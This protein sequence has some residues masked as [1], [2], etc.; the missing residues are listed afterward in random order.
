MMPIGPLMIEHRLI[1]RAIKQMRS[2]MERAKARKGFDVRF[3]DSWVDFI[4]TYADQVHHGKEE[5]I[6]FHDLESRPLSPELKRMMAGLIEDHVKA[7]KMVSELVMARDQYAEGDPTAFGRLMALGAEMVDFYPAHIRKEDQ[8]FFI[9]VMEYFTKGEKD[10]M[11]K[12]FQA[13]DESVIHEH[14]RAVV[15]T[16]EK[17]RSGSETI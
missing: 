4:R 3:I 12:R 16:M 10:E 13:F 14:Y 5:R 1:E 17:R 15:E 2:E 6:L 8:E 11:L 7:R 9:P